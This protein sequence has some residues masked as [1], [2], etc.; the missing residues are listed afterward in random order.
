MM[1]RAPKEGASHLR[2]RTNQRVSAARATAKMGRQTSECVMLR[3][4][5]KMSRLSC[6]KKSRNTSESGKIAPS[7]RDQ[8][9]IRSR[10]TSF[11]PSMSCPRKAALAIRAPAMPCVMVSMRE[12]LPD[13]L[14]E[15]HFRTP[16]GAESAW[17]RLCQLVAPQL[18]DFARQQ[19]QFPLP[20]E[21]WRQAGRPKSADRR[22]DLD[23]RPRRSARNWRSHSQRRDCF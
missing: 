1:I 16:R 3:C 19:E 6:E 15:E 4:Q 12:S 20:P 21:R 17:Q 8:V 13:Y 14:G 10:F 9:T 18:R 7:I 11:A 2:Q 23:T 5:V 22:G